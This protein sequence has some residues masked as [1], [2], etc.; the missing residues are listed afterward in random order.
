MAFLNFAH[1]AYRAIVAYND[2]HKRTWFQSSSSVLQKQHDFF[3]QYIFPFR[4][5]VCHKL[6]QLLLTAVCLFLASFLNAVLKAV[7]YTL[8]NGCSLH[9]SFTMMGALSF[10][11]FNCD[12]RWY[13]MLLVIFVRGMNSVAFSFGRCGKF[14]FAP[15]TPLSSS[16]IWSANKSAST[17]SRSYFVKGLPS[18]SALPLTHLTITSML[19]YHSV[20]AD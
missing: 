5:P 6:R 3:P 8:P 15:Y 9:S 19:S 20:C 14:G 13:F 12:V 16:H 1:E 4:L 18:R 2:L 17:L 11:S 7:Q 10:G